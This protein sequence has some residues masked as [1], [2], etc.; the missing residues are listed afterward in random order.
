M[1][2]ILIIDSEIRWIFR[3]ILFYRQLAEIVLPTKS[4]YTI[5]LYIFEFLGNALYAW[6]YICPGFSADVRFLCE[7]A[8][9]LS[10]KFR[11]YKLQMLYLDNREQMMVIEVFT[12]KLTY[13]IFYIF[14]TSIQVK[15]FFLPVHC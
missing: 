4:V 15:A 8:E 7:S 9:R 6:K 12:I 3:W 2:C 13:G 14:Y 1:L 11:H 5:D 10:W